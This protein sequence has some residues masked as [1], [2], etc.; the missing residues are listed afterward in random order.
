MI[1]NLVRSLGLTYQRN[2]ATCFHLLDDGILDLNDLIDANAGW[3]LTY[4][5]LTSTTA[6]RSSSEADTST[7]SSTLFTDLVPE[8]ATLGP[9][10]LAAAVAA[11]RGRKDPMGLANS[12]VS[13]SPPGPR[14]RS[15]PSEPPTSR[16]T[17]W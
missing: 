12:V 14:G 16:P 3:E 13:A 10:L 5:L 9:L 7:A 15:F 2:N 11:S 4:A 6:A 8:P 17:S 1:N